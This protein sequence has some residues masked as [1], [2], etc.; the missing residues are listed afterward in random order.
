[1]IS[2]P[3]PGPSEDSPAPYASLYS[4]PGAPD[5]KFLRSASEVLG[6]LAVVV[7]VI[8]AVF[9]IVA[10]A[11][12]GNILFFLGTGLVV[13]VQVILLLV[14]AHIIR[15]LLLMERLLRPRFLEQ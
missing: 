1:M 9:A 11:I 15:L 3:E 4:G 5:F 10:L 12:S 13:T 2:P 8:G 14:V 7:G 6:I